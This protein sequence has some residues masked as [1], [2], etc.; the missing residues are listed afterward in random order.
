MRHWALLTALAPLLACTPVTL[1]TSLEGPSGSA[2]CLALAPLADS[3]A[4]A[5]QGAGVP[6]KV[7]ITGARL[8]AGLD[9]GCGR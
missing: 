5:L 2:L 8:V 1:P 4:A 7:L 9:K 6:D 3:H